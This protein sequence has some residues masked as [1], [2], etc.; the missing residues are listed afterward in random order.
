MFICENSEWMHPYL[1]KCCRGTC[2]FVRLLKGYMVRKRL[3]YGYPWW[4]WIRKKHSTWT[5]S[6]V[7]VKVNLQGR[8]Y[9]IIG[10][11]CLNRTALS[12]CHRWSTNGFYASWP[13]PAIC[14]FAIF[15]SSQCRRRSFASCWSERAKSVLQTSAKGNGSNLLQRSCHSHGLCLSQLQGTHETLCRWTSFKP[16]R[17]SSSWKICGRPTSRIPIV[18]MVRKCRGKTGIPLI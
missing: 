17:C 15:E 7:T 2:S 8:Y 3:G 10:W 1:L 11:F 16:T 12:L 6:T 5:L 4:I 18:K 14:S 9:I 13:I